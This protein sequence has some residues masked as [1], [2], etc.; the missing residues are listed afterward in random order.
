MPETACWHAHVAMSAQR[1]LDTKSPR[2]AGQPHTGI[3]QAEQHRA[4]PYS[5]RGASVA[6]HTARAKALP[7]VQAYCYS[8]SCVLMHTHM[9][10][11]AG[12]S[13][14]R[15]AA[16]GTAFIASVLA[17]CA[18]SI[19][20]LTIATSFDKNC[21]GNAPATLQRQ[22]CCRQPRTLLHIMAS[23]SRHGASVQRQNTS[24]GTNR[25]VLPGSLTI[26]IT[27]IPCA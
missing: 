4:K 24:A 19:T 12:T 11:C 17:R 22:L 23:H 21:P 26:C 1:R 20:A 15:G 18:V 10:A 9:H 2:K 14:C 13:Q 7:K 25:A 27:A 8:G 5:R 3:W 6:L 16:C